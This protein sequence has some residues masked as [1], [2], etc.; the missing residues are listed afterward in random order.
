MINEGDRSP[1]FSLQADDNSVVTRDSLKGK[2]AILFFYP[3]DDTSGCTKEACA[4]RDAFPEFG[5]IDATVL[6]VSPDGID[7]HRKFKKKYD[8]PYKLLVDE[9][10]RLADAFGVWKEKSLY[11]RKYMGIERTTV[12]LDR[13]GRVARIFPKVKIPGH[14]QEVERAVREMD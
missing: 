9:N 14:V 7:S 5:K 1:E 13:N 4:F 3:K 6:G 12:I 10:H 11:G 2:K 8:L